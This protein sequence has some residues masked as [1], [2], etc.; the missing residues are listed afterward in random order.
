MRRLLLAL[1]PALLQVLACALWTPCHGM[2]EITAINHRIVSDPKN[3]D[4]YFQRAAEKLKYLDYEGCLENLTRSIE[5]K[6]TADKYFMRAMARRETGKLVDAESDFEKSAQLSPHSQNAYAELACLAAKLR[7]YDKANRAF[8]EL[9]KLN[10][11]RFVERS[12]R[13]EMYLQMKRPQAAL[14]EIETCLKSDA[15]SG[16]RCH[17]I[18]GQAC[19]Q[20]RQYVR[21]VEAFTFAIKK[22]EFN[23]DARRG[24]LEAYEKL[25]NTKMA[26]Q[27]KRKLD[28]DLSEAFHIAPFRSK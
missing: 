19:V 15:D 28:E 8:D 3:S 21:A 22:N 25:G 20:L 12:R 26:Q 11:S 14:S 27:E 9:F 7:H 18:L 2:D 5:L 23:I 6:P 16:G 13:A 1:I 10:P 17:T 4:L 24:R